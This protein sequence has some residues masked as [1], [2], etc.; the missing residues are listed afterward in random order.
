MYLSLIL[1]K[2][3]RDLIL[4]LTYCLAESDNQMARE[5]NFAYFGETCMTRMGISKVERYD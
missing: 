4:I 1:S 2:Y 5:K 3:C